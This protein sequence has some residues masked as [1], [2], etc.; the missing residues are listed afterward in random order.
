VFPVTQKSP[1]TQLDIWVRQFVQSNIKLVQRM[2][3]SSGR[4]L[5]KILPDFLSKT[6][7]E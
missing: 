2:I 3:E 5:A 1:E 7:E 4:A 6:V